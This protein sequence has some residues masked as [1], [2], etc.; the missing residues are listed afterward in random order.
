MLEKYTSPNTARTVKPR[1]LR[2]VGRVAKMGIQRMH[3]K[4]WWENLLEN[5][6]LEDR[7]GVGG[8]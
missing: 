4:F 6:D 7:G 8:G 2:W 5:V 1:R 3:T